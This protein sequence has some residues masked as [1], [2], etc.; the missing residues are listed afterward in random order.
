[1]PAAVRRFRFG[2]HS[3]PGSGHGRQKIRRVFAGAYEPR[4]KGRISGPS[5]RY[6]LNQI[7]SGV[8][9]TITIICIAY[10]DRIFF[11]CSSRP[12]PLKEC[13]PPYQNQIRRKITP[14]HIRNRTCAHSLNRAAGRDRPDGMRAGQPHR[15][16]GL[17]AC[18]GRFWTGDFSMRQGPEPSVTRGQSGSA[19]GPRPTSA[20]LNQH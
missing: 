18:A 5:S 3:E 16:C 10:S 14:F 4:Q 6:A 11:F 19:G 7:A 8:P 15:T 9:Y 12:R 1:M 2:W 17:A 13:S 20:F